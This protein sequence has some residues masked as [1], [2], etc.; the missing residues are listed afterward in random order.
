MQITYKYM[1][2]K[3]KFSLIIPIYNA[4]LFILDNLNKLFNYCIK[5]KIELV[6][7]NDGSSDSTDSIIQN[8]INKVEFDKYNFKYLNLLNNSGKGRAIKSALSFTT[9]DFIIFTDCDL[10]YSFENID[11][12]INM[13]IDGESKIV[14]ANRMHP[15]SQYLIRSS[16]LSYIYIRHTAGRVF[17]LLVRILSNLDIM[18]TQAGLK[19][20][21]RNAAL[22][23]FEKMTVVGFSF[24]IDILACA[25]SNNFIINS[26]PIDFN[27]E[28]EMSTINFA[29]QILLMTIDLLKIRF[30]II[31]G[32]YK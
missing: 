32:K 4:E 31:I 11:R 18:D 17:N 3:N 6:L 13:L 21:E 22:I 7:V 24:D 19:G 23:I 29:R 15:N 25:K 30:K 2:K 1:H 28:T 12:V 16:K 27:Y 26:I 20:F 8:F 10:P 14:I 5:N 9:G